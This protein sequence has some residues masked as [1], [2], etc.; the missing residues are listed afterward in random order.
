[1]TLNKQGRQ[2][3]LVLNLSA[4]AVKLVEGVSSTAEAEAKVPS[5]IRLEMIPPNN[6][7][8]QT[9][10]APDHLFDVYADF[11]EKNIFYKQM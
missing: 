5:N 6:V 8:L 11:L 3:Y 9:I 1:M 2:Q 4:A 7:C 10:Q